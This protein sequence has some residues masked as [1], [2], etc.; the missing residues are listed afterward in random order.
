MAF[1]TLAAITLALFGGIAAVVADDLPAREKAFAEGMAKLESRHGGRLGVAALDLGER[2]GYSHRGGER[3]AM[4]STFKFLLAAA[5]AARVDAGDE[6]WDRKIPYGKKD[7]I[8]W[9]PVTG[10]EENLEAGSM[11]VSDLCE[12]SMTWSDNT[13]ANLLLAT[14]GGPEGFTRYLR[15]IGDATTRLDR[16][17]PGLN[18]NV[19]GD[20]RDTSTPDAMVATMEKLLFGE[21]L[22]EA[23]KEKL[24]GWLVANHTG[25]KRIRAAM[26]PAWRVGDKTG[27]GEN[28]AANDIAVI[29]PTGRKP[30]LIVVF[31]DAVQATAEQRDTVIAD[32]AKLVRAA[33]EVE[34]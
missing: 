21:S 26:D 11:T 28:G 5:V 31:Y 33:L 29:W 17:E 30:F 2:S 8:P 15:S 16:I 9:T 10:K 24:I 1:Q 25:D 23:S 34:K 12:A 6:Q 14:I 3:F 27:T 18:A 4:C 7:L 13:A 32:A 22:A 20:E 19:R